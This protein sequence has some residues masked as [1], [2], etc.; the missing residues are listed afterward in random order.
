MT[1][2][3]GGNDSKDVRTGMG[4]LGYEDGRKRKLLKL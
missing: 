4:G 3:N 1:A 2:K